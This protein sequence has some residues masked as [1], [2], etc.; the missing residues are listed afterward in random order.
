MTKRCSCHNLVNYATVQ[1][2]LV[3]A[4]RDISNLYFS[5]LCLLDPVVVVSSRGKLHYQRQGRRLLIHS[6]WLVL[7]IL[8]TGSPMNIQIK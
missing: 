4:R 2:Q 8:A 3:H 1:M 6:H 5:F 7:E